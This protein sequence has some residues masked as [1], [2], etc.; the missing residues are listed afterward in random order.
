[1]PLMT[2]MLPPVMLVVYLS[3][4]ANQPLTR[5]GSWALNYFQ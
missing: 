4:Y 5:I 3:T 2:R 1:M